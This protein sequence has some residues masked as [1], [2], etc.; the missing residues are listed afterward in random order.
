MHV[1]ASRE[2]GKNTNREPLRAPGGSQPPRYGLACNGDITRRASLQPPA[3]SL[4]NAA[5]AEYAS[6]R[7]RDNYTTGGPYAMTLRVRS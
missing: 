5:M 6:Q 4:S 1:A 7:P 2:N 3:L